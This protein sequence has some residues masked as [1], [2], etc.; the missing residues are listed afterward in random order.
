MTEK[1]N[2]AFTAHFNEEK[3]VIAAIF[4]SVV[5][6]WEIIGSERH[7]QVGAVGRGIC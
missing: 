4:G 2:D 5:I 3:K 6:L 7:M 1:K